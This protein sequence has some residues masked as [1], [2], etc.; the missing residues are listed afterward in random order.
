MQMDYD[1]AY[2]A[3]EEV[4]TE[5]GP[6]FVFGGCSFQLRQLQIGTPVA[7]GMKLDC[8]VFLNLDRDLKRRSETLRGAIGKRR[9]AHRGCEETL[10]RHAKLI[11]VCGLGK[12]S[13]LELA[14]WNHVGPVISMLNLLGKYYQVSH[15]NFNHQVSKRHF[16]SNEV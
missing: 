10:L 1:Q 16:M 11:P 3:G 7:R 8:A 6:C 15:F 2:G 9:G 4:I 14:S 13:D 5:H 12:R